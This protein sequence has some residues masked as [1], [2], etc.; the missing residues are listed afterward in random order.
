M[1]ISFQTPIICKKRALRF[2]RQGHAYKTKE[3]KDC[4]QALK[5]E[6][7]IQTRG[8]IQKIVDKPVRVV[9]LFRKAGRRGRADVLGLAETM[10]D[11]LEGV[12]YTNDHW[13]H[14][15]RCQ[16]SD[17]LTA[18]TTALVSVNEICATAKK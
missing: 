4:E 6:A 3:S 7:W 18:P 2:T 17:T 5:M 16:W 13:I 8:G 11:A 15:L 12:A 9:M 10:A 14:D 1:E